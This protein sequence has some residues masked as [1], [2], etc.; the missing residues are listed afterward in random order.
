[1]PPLPTLPPPLPGTA[2]RMAVVIPT[3]AAILHAPATFGRA[4]AIGIGLNI[5]FVVIEDDLR[6]CQRVHGPGGGC[7]PQPLGRPRAPRRLDRLG[8][9]QARATARSTYGLRGSSILAALFN[10]VFLL[11]ATGAIAREAVARL[12][13][14]SPSRWRA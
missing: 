6:L 3:G 9:G 7:R 1:M 2:I 10:A 8:A 5:A 4:F 13:A 11:V 12:I 14:A